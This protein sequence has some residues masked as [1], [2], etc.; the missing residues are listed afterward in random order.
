MKTELSQTS[1][2]GMVIVMN[3]HFLTLALAVC[4]LTADTATA[5][6]IYEPYSISTF[7]GSVGQNGN[8]DGTGSAAR[9]NY[10]AGVAVDSAKNVYVADSFN[11][12]IRKITPGGVVTTVATGFSGSSSP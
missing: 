10:P 9:F 2:A 6:S 7:A 3:K 5:Q 4:A 11:G 12:R 8:T 1:F